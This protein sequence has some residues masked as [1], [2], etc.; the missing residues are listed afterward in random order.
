[1]DAI[2]QLKIADRLATGTTSYAGT[3][4]ARVH[5]VEL[6]ATR[7][8]GYMIPPGATFS[9]NQA[10]GPPPLGAGDTLPWGVVCTRTGGQYIAAE[11]LPAEAGGLCQVATTLFH[12]IFRAGLPIEERHWHLYWI[13]RYGVAPSGVTGLDATVDDPGVD[14]KFVNTTGNWLA[15][16]TRLDRG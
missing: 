5:N 2:G 16:Q 13:P 11:A 8:N 9:F 4:A 3:I 6:A 14:L 12:A 15:I 1:G 7:L 10:V